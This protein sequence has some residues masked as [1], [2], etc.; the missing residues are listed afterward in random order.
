MPF[1]SVS[2]SPSLNAICRS[3]RLAR[4]ARL[5][6]RAI[7][8][9]VAVLSRN[10]AK[11][12]CLRA[13]GAGRPA[14][15]SEEHVG[16]LAESMCQLRLPRIERHVYLL[17]ELQLLANIS[18]ARVRVAAA[19][20]GEQRLALVGLEPRGQGLEGVADVVRRA[21]GVSARV[22]RVEILCISSQPLIFNVGCSALWETH[23]GRQ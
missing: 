22:V 3:L 20:L 18:L 1:P 10:L 6:Q 13:E 12:V 15:I 14:N 8:P 4:E 11:F 7:R 16:V 2:Y 5:D 19:G 21:L 17:Q 23:C 9:R